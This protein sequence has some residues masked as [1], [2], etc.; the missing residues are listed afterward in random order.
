MLMQETTASVEYQFRASL[1]LPVISVCVAKAFKDVMVNYTEEEY[2]A[3]T[4]DYGEIFG[5]NNSAL[6]NVTEVPTVLQ[7]RCYSFHKAEEV[8]TAISISEGITLKTAFGEDLNIIMHHEDEEI[9][10]M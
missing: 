7:G 8:T 1:K 4:Y 3:K 6:W 5:P 9:W 2:L 10:L